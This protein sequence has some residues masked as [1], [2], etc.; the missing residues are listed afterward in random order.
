[1][2]GEWKPGIPGAPLP[3]AFSSGRAAATAAPAVTRASA[4][5]LRSCHVSKHATSVKLAHQLN[6][7]VDRHKPSTSRCVIQTWTVGCRC[8]NR[9]DPGPVEAQTIM[10]IVVINILYNNHENNDVNVNIKVK[11]NKDDDDHRISTRSR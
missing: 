6:C 11:S 9:E 8:L 10:M 4:A 1:M 3:M 7:H 5:T 2:S